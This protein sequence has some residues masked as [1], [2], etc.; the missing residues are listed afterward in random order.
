MWDWGNGVRSKE[1]G[2][3][4]ILVV[5]ISAAGDGVEVAKVDVVIENFV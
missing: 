2:E 3:R 4:K 1:Q 5:T